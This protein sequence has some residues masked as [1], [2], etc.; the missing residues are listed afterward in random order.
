M[1]YVAA[2]FIS[3]I[4]S[5]GVTVTVMDSSA[6]QKIEEVRVDE[7]NS[8]W[9]DGYKDGYDQAGGQQ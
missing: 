5:V 3:A 7:F 9:M 2:V 8:G 6:H 4:L 1:K